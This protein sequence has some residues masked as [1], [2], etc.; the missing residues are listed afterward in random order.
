MEGVGGTGIN[1]GFLALSQLPLL[2]YTNQNNSP[3]GT[4]L[5]TLKVMPIARF[6]L[7]LPRIP[8]PLPL[9]VRAGVGREFRVWKWIRIRDKLR[10]TSQ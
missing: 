5:G 4:I 7:S 10:R 9:G 2:L 6:S 1:S 8:I 3:L